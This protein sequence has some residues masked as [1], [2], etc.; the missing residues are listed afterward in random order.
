MEYTNRTAFKALK[1]QL[2]HARE[3]AFGLIIYFCLK[4]KGIFQIH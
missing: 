2:S 4:Y 3:C 1:I